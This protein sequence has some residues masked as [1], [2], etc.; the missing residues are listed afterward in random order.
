[1][2]EA[3]AK[4]LHFSNCKLEISKIIKK[5]RGNHKGMPQHFLNHYSSSLNA[6][7]HFFTGYKNT[8]RLAFLWS[9]SVCPVT[10]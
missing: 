9:N 6:I 7:G 5:Y 8:A 2:N 10:W 1:M 3:S 4:I